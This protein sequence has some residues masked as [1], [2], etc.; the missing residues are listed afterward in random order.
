MPFPN[1]D[2]IAFSIGPLPIRW[3][4]LAYLGAVVFGAL[5][6]LQLLKKPQL[7]GLKERGP[8]NSVQLSDVATVAALGAIIGGRLGYVCFYQPDL[9]IAPWESL[10]SM[11]GGDNILKTLLGWIPIPPAIMMWRGGMSFHGGLL[12]VTI[13]GFL[14]ARKHKL[15]AL[16]L[17]D[18]F[19]CAAPIGLF[20][21]RMANFVNGELF[22]RPTDVSWG[23]VFPHAPDSLPRH[24]SQLYEAGLEGVMMF[25]IIAVATF[26]FGLLKHKGAAIG[27]WIA[28]YGLS[29]IIIENFRQPDAHL[30]PFP[31]GLTMGMLLSTPMVVLGVWLIWR[32]Y[33][34]PLGVIEQA[35]EIIPDTPPV[36]DNPNRK[37]KSKKS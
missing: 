25:I 19:A 17:G 6:L 27:V 21:G 5:Y 36:K 16:V 33:T 14:Y 20:F 3:Y 18:L 24:P 8:L 15:D 23:M 12:G 10:G 2:P 28:G 1:I 37:Q 30:D 35:P 31:L 32:G 22:G 4:S 34:K 13:A 9:L 11:I 7:W 29:R 26:S